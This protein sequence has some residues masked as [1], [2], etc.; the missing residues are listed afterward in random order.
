MMKPL[1]L[2]WYVPETQIPVFDGTRCH[3]NHQGRYI[4]RTWNVQLIIESWNTRDLRSGAKGP[5]SSGRVP[6]WKNADL[7]EP[8]FLAADEY[9]VV[10]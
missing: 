9:Q 7:M 2:F 6:E 10:L 5:L 3:H 4:A 1:H 8:L